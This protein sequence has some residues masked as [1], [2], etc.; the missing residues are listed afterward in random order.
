MDR[1]PFGVVRSAGGSPTGGGGISG[2]SNDGTGLPVFEA[3]E[4]QTLVFRSIRA[5]NPAITVQT[6]C[7]G[8]LLIGLDTSQLDMDGGTY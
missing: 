1:P 2:A 7:L 8:N 4:G 5:Q 3:Q 6:D